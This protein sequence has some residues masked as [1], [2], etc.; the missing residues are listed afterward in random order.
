[1]Y[2]QKLIEDDTSK[3]HC[4]VMHHGESDKQSVGDNRYDGRGTVMDFSN[5]SLWE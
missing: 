5:P 2:I 1:M 3:E 4:G